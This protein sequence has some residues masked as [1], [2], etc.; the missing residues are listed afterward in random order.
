MAR[1][2]LLNE[3][4]IRR[5]MKLASIKPLTEGDYG[6]EREEED[7][8]GMRDM[9]EQEGEEEMDMGG[10]EAMDMDMG[11][12]EMD[13]EE[14]MDD[15]GAEGGME[16][17]EDK[18]QQFADIV[19]QLATLLDLDAEVEVGEEEEE[20]EVEDEEGGEPAMSDSDL[21]AGEGEEEEMGDEEEME[22]E[23]EEVIAE[24]ARRVAARLLKQKRT[25]IKA[26]K[27]A[28]AIF[29]RLASK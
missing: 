12:E 7:P 5:F 9:Y 14:P 28:E 27:L 10:E 8:P 2:T 13:M 29:R 21:E 3:S 18:E 4:E 25:E 17:G 22:G 6:K 16:A 1:K 26:N 15:M 20:V 11:G 23:E 19:S 24:V